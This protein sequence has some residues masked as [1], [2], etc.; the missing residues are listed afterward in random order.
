VRPESDSD[1]PLAE[2]TL[3]CLSRS[4]SSS[5]KFP[6]IGDADRSVATKYDMLDGAF[7][8]GLQPWGLNG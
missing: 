8:R 7:A 6:I 3:I 4:M 5:V 1:R 2:L